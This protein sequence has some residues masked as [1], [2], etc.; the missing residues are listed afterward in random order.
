MMYK[1]N[2]PCLGCGKTGEEKP[3]HSKDSLCY[4]CIDLLNIGRATFQEKER[5]REIYSMD[6]LMTAFMTWYAI[7]VPEID[8]AM[9]D[10]LRTFSKFDQ[11]YSGGASVHCDRMLAGAADSCTSHD[12]FVL[13]KETFEAAKKLCQILKD[14]SWNL[15]RD[16][17][18]YKKELQ[19]QLA[20][21][22]D[23]IF[24]EGVKYGRN[25]L[26]QLNNNEITPDQFVAPVKKYAQ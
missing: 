21:E 18:N 8:H 2:A 4:D 25:L 12:N 24:N 22:K 7:P 26:F 6:D 14:T 1:G 11:R 13:P 9:R 23:A 15:K 3:R 20:N 16:R 19:K 10:L 5:E 17:E